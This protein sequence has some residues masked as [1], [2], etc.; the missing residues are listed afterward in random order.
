MVNT[1]WSDSH[2]T[3]RG[4][5]HGSE[6]SSWGTIWPSTPPRDCLMSIRAY[7]YIPDDPKKTMTEW[8][9]IIWR[10][11]DLD[12]LETAQQRRGVMPWRAPPL[13]AASALEHAGLKYI[14]LM[15]LPERRRDAITGREAVTVF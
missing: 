9:E 1:T 3:P 14:R 10:T 12:A 8:S 5:R 2:L 7:S 4:W 13:S 11:D 15:Q 6:V